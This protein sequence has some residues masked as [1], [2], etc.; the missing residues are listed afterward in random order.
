MNTMREQFLFLLNPS[1][2]FRL[3]KE[4]VQSL[5]NP[6]IKQE[7]PFTISNLRIVVMVF[8]IGFIFK[9]VGL[10]ANQLISNRIDTDYS[11][12]EKIPLIITVIFVGIIAPIIEELIFRLPLKFSAQNI[13]ISSS[14]FLFTFSIG[15][16][17]R[18][19]V[20]D[21]FESV[22][23]QKII[24]LSILIIIS[25]LIFR[26][27]FFILIKFEDKISEMSRHHF[28]K[29]FYFYTIAFGLIHITNFPITMKS[30]LFIIPV[31]LPQI[32]SGF[33]LGYT[34]INYGLKY[35]IFQHSLGNMALIVFS[36]SG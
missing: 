9:I 14:I 32:I 33:F 12:S 28:S 27:L 22:I 25:Y 19:K 17:I 20:K 1:A 13:A 16:T 29:F 24:N 10:L 26:L 4:I 35:S 3:F 2:Y 5:L 21:I 18:D 15:Y 6:E 7:K 34:R 23:L 11:H 31:T 36:N 8:I 30:I